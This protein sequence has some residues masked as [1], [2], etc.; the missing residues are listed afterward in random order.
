MMPLFSNLIVMFHYKVTKSKSINVCL[1]NGCGTSI[2]HQ[3]QM[4]HLITIITINKLIE[5]C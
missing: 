3:P 5:L 2:W 1:M 4:I